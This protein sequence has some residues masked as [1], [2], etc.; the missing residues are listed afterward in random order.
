MTVTDVQKNGE[1]LCKWLDDSGRVSMHSFPAAALKR[2]RKTIPPRSGAEQT[3][4]VRL[5]YGSGFV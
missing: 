4:D 1:L 2:L 5:C 3:L